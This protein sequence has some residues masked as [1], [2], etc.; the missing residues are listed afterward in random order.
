MHDDVLS[1]TIQYLV[2]DS[3]TNHGIKN[4]MLG[5]SS[6][7]R[8]EKLDI[9]K[10]GPWLNRGIGS[11][12]ITSLIRYLKFSQLAVEPSI[13]FVYAGENDLSTGLSSAEVFDQYKALIQQLGEKFPESDIHIIGI[14][15]SPRRRSR[16]E[17]FMAVNAMIRAYANDQ[18]GIFFHP[19]PGPETEFDEIGFLDDGVH[20]TEQ[21][22]RLFTS[23]FNEACAK[24]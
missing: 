14:K 16:R 17:S 18:P 23:G 8:L 11:S 22:Y 3:T 2:E 20:L 15:L 6:I 4:L 9:L 19:T 7:K 1:T 5:S 21:G 24:Q 12:R 10:C 13:V